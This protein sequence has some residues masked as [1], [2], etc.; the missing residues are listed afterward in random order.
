MP[1]RGNNLFTTDPYAA[2]A[3]GAS[4]VLAGR[5]LV[6]KRM[7][8][9]SMVLAFSA[10]ASAQERRVPTVDE[11][12][13]FRSPDSATLSPDGR[14]VAY[15]V[16]DTLWAENTYGMQLWLASART[17]E[18]VKLTNSKGVNRDPAWSPD[19]RWL[20]FIS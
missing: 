10:A 18:M 20:A 6:V 13:A 9:L 4:H 5:D 7:T 19:G 17:G 3:R 11:L 12:I 2:S 15:T 8:I 14:F 1:F 16:R